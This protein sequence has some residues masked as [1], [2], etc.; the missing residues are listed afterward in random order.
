[1]RARLVKQFVLGGLMATRCCAAAGS[2]QPS[3][4]TP[5]HNLASDAV[6][7]ASESQGSLIPDNARD[8]DLGTRWSGIPGHNKD[9]WF[10]LEWRQP[11]RLGELV[12]HQFDRYTMEMDIQV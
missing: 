10:Q 7:T 6:A 1:M 3:V 8:G 4:S 2:G 11:V 12:I 5:R 9:V